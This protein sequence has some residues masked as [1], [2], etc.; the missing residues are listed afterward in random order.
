MSLHELFKSCNGLRQPSLDSLLEVLLHTIQEF[1]QTY[2]VLDALD[3]SLDRAELTAV[4]ERMAEWK[5]RGSH[6]L[7]TSREQNDL[8]RSLR[9]IVNTQNIIWFQSELVDRDILAYV[10]QTL[11]NDRTGGSFSKWHEDPNLRDEIETALTTAL[12]KGA[13]GMYA[14]TLV[15]LQV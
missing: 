14:Y 7:V 8:Q 12:T 2:I 1:P 13:H 4:L 9:S 5:L 6:L 3:E 11:S 15:S 10:R